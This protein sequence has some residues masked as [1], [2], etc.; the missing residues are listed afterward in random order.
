LVKRA[1]LL[2]KDE[3][4]NGVAILKRV[5]NITRAQRE[6]AELDVLIQEVATHKATL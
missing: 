1:N 6:L 2:K 4:N 3:S 5:C